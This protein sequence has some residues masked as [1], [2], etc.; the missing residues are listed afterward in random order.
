MYIYQS[1]FSFDK[2]YK[3]NRPTKRSKPPSHK[4]YNIPQYVSHRTHSFHEAHQESHVQINRSHELA[5]RFKPRRGILRGPGG[6]DLGK[7]ARDSTFSVRGSFPPGGPIG[8]KVLRVAVF[9][10]SPSRNET[11]K[12]DRARRARARALRLTR[13][14]RFCVYRGGY[15]CNER[16]FE[17]YASITCSAGKLFFCKGWKGSLFI[18]CGYL[19][20]L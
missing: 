8:L 6:S 7:S 2:S 12:R 9:F 3:V 20:Y 15:M 13:A 16:L 18:F 17:V 11:R 14:L 1:N 4:T 5:R 10:A 19:L